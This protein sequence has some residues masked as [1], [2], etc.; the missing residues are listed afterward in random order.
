MKVSFVQEG[1]HGAAGTLRLGL[2]TN[3][4]IK[5]IEKNRYREFLYRHMMVASMSILFHDSK[6]RDC[7]R[8]NSIKQIE[9]EDFPF[10]ALLTYVDILQDDRRDATGSSSRPD[11]LKDI[12]VEDGKRIVAKLEE[13]VLTEGTKKKLFE[14]LEEALSFFIMNGLTFAI[15]QELSTAKAKKYEG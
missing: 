13:R 12:N 10:S 6:V 1:S 15:P 11:I 7:F 4:Q 14:D 2:L 3:K 8:N 9:V 5:D